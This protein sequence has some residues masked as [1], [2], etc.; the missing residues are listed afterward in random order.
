MNAIQGQVLLRGRRGGVDGIAPKDSF[1]LQFILLLPGRL[2]HDA[3]RPTV[4]LSV[5]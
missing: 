4:S 3:E 5:T 2:S 1:L